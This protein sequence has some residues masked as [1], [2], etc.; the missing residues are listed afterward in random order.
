MDLDF[1]F[2]SKFNF[3]MIFA[4]IVIKAEEPSGFC[5]ENSFQFEEKPQQ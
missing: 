5:E 4:R 3:F 1:D 2:S